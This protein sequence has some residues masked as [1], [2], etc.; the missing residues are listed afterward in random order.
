MVQNQ[1]II[2]SEF[3]LDGN[4]SHIAQTTVRGSHTNAVFY[5]RNVGSINA[6]TLHSQ[7]VGITIEGCNNPASDRAG[8]VDIID[9]IVKIDHSVIQNNQGH[10]GGGV[11]AYGWNTRLVISNSTIANNTSTGSSGGLDIREIRRLY[12][13]NT[14]IS[15]NTSN[16]DNGGAIIRYIQYATIT[17]LVVEDNYSNG[18]YP[19]GEWYINGAGIFRNITLRNNVGWNNSNHSFRFRQ[20]GWNDPAPNSPITF[21]NLQLTGNVTQ[22]WPSMYIDGSTQVSLVNSLVSDNTSRNTSDWYQ[23]GNIAIYD[24]THLRLLNSIVTK[25]NGLSIIGNGCG[26]SNVSARY[27]VIE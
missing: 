4:V 22:S 2:A 10:I 11:A 27:S 9:A 18:S 21:Y 25:N 17:D 15:E 6:D 3:I 24:N 20:E 13:R 23:K 5:Y 12:L 26:T 16:G 8:G 1:V 14:R 19:V 7:L